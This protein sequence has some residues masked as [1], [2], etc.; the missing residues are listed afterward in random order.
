MYEYDA[1][2]KINF[3][4]GKCIVCEIRI[5][6]GWIYINPRR[7]FRKKRK[8]AWDRYVFGRWESNPGFPVET[9]DKSITI[10]GCAPYTTS[11]SLSLFR[12]GAEKRSRAHFGIS[13]RRWR[14]P[15]ASPRSP[16]MISSQGWRDSERGRPEGVP[17]ETGFKFRMGLQSPGVVVILLIFGIPKESSQ[18]EVKRRKKVGEGRK[19]L[20]DP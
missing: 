5:N 20:Q 13:R 6:T 1:Q 16:G 8:K 4:V 2:N 10:R 15:P 17:Q 9:A 11:D 3:E 18:K 12:T 14:A 7:A 19:A